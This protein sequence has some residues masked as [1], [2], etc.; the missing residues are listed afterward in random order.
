MKKNQTQT[1]RN[2]KLEL[3]RQAVRELTTVDLAAVVGGG[4]QPPTTCSEA[5]FA[6]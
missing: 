5:T 6:A 4:T 3:K 1:K 2:P